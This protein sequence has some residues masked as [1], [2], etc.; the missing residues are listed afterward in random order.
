MRPSGWAV[1][2]TWGM[3]S[4]SVRYSCSRSRSARSASLSGVMSWK[5]TTPTGGCPFTV[6][7]CEDS[8]R[9][10]VRPCGVSTVICRPCTLSPRAVRA[11]GISSGGMAVPSRWRTTTVRSYSARL[12]G[13]GKCPPH[14]RSAAALVK[15][16]RPLP[17]S[18]STSGTGTRCSTASSHCCCA[19][20]VAL[21]AST[22]CCAC[23]CSVTSRKTLPTAATAP[24]S[25]R[26]GK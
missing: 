10:A 1:H 17:R 20:S 26:T 23:A 4:A 13:L 2:T 14:S 11:L 18:T 15:L 8:T 6:G 9:M 12:S 3:D 22:R 7:T 19:A 21:S 16:K 24:P 25:P 5:V